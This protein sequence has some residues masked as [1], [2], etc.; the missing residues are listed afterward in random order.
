MTIEHLLTMTS[1]LSWPEL[2]SSYL[3]SSNPVRQMFGSQDAV[4]FVL[5]RPMEEEPGARFNY[6]TGASHLLSGVIQEATGISTLSFAQKNL[7]GPLGISGVHWPS[8]P[9]GITAGGIGIRMTPR[10]MLR[11]GYLYLNGGIWDDAPVVPGEW[12][13]TSTTPPSIG[14]DH[15]GYQWRLGS[16]A[17][18]A[19]G[20]RGQRIE[21]APEL[22]MVVVITGEQSIDV[23]GLLIDNFIFEAAKSSEALPEN[24]EAVAM[25]EARVKELGQPEPDLVPLLPETARRVSG[26]TYVLDTNNVLGSS[27]PSLDWRSV[28][29]DFQRDSVEALIYLS[30]TNG[31]PQWELTIGLDNVFRITQV[32]DFGPVALKGYWRDGKTFFLQNQLLGPALWT[33]L[34]SDTRLDLTFTLEQDVLEVQLDSLSLSLRTQAELQD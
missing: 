12:I 7:F 28:S 6:N 16:E 5:D 19:L 10:D 18:W 29:F 23:N 11:F 13:E 32:D 15:Y 34:G 21:K 24:P 22:A 14:S 33:G 25:L 30:Y 17:Y 27:A 31:P 4:Q 8:D 1:G 3:S 9:A 26:N 2:N 20:W